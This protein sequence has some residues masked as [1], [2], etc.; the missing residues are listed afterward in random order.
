MQWIKVTITALG[1]FAL[2]QLTIA[3]LFGILSYSLQSIPNVELKSDGNVF[4]IM[5]TDDSLGEVIYT[6]EYIKGLA[7]FLPDVLLPRCGG[8]LL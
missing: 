8:R 4:N 5:Y 7:R 6:M 1:V 2:F 3:F